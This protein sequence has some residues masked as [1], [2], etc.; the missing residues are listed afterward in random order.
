MD[1]YVISMD[2]LKEAS[3]ILKPG[4]SPGID[5]VDNETILCLYQ[6]HPRLILKLFNKI[7]TTKQKVL[8]W[9]VA[10]I[11][12]IYKNGAMDNPANFRGIS[13]LSCLGNFF[14]TVLNNRLIKFVREQNILSESQLG[15]IAGNRTSDAHILQ[16]T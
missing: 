14:Y 16:I 2:E 4:K 10:I 13:L 11:S 15:F 9:S 5:E 7:Y 6:E 1:P 3:S 12:L 8:Q